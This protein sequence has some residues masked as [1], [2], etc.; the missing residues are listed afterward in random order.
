MVSL[1]SQ[2]IS[3]L[4]DPWTLKKLQIIKGESVGKFT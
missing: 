1:T 2:H 3:N 4:K